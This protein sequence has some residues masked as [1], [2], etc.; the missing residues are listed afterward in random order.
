MTASS[1][2]IRLGATGLTSAPLALGTSAIGGREPA[3]ARAALL[4]AAEAGIH[5]WDSSNNYGRS[6]EYV[7]AALAELGPGS[8]IQV[9]T[10]VDPLPGSADFS[11]TRV[12]ASVEESLTRLGRDHLPLVHLH[13]PERISFADAMAPGGPVE[14]LVALRDEGVIGHLGVAGG[15]VSLLERFVRTG[16]FEAVVTHNRFTLVDRSA[17]T[18]LDL[19]AERGLA[20]FNAAPFGSGALARDDGPVGTYQ[21]R[22]PDPAVAD[23]V[24]ALR[25]IAREAGVPIAALALAFSLADP[26]VDVTIVG[27]TDPGRI[28]EIARLARVTVPAGV[29]DEVEAVVPTTQIG[30]QHR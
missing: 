8:D 2:S 4:A 19:C 5:D 6:E 30:P 23:A 3:Q 21:Y 17:A 29:W 24:L 20:T 27:S 25:R 14:A 13:D 12:R 26:R 28:A 9:F 7:G 1:R 22:E 11:G 18:L 16:A 10:K 15:P